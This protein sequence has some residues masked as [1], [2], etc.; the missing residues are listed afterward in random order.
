MNSAAMENK[1]RRGG[2]STKDDYADYL[3][4]ISEYG[5]TVPTCNTIAIKRKKTIENM[6]HAERKHG[7]ESVTWFDIAKAIKG[8]DLG[9]GHVGDFKVACEWHNK[10]KDYL[11]SKYDLNELKHFTEQKSSSF[12]IYSRLIIS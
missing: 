10:S 4:H 7:G 6:I 5:N 2:L 1:Y 11:L 8:D 3:W 12:L 9:E